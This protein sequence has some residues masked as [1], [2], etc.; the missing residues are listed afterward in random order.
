M[1]VAHLGAES[2]A[3]QTL[4]CYLSAIR[5]LSIMAAGQGDPFEPGTF[6]VPQYGPQGSKA[7]SQASKTTPAHNSG[8][9]PP[10]QE[11][12]GAAHAR[13]TDYKM[14]WAACCVVF[15]GS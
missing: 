9:P 14:L 13:E 7:E 1:F 10:P 4:K 15:G 3:Y 6:P 11:P 5:H 8:D 2:L 12:M